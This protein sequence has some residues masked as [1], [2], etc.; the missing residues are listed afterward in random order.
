MR[1]EVGEGAVHLSNEA[2]EHLPDHFSAAPISL[3]IARRRE[4][5][6]AFEAL[7]VLEAHVEVRRYCRSN[8]VSADVKATGELELAVFLDDDIGCGRAQIE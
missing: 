1:P 2:C 5:F 7:G 4:A 8:V 3:R 6:L